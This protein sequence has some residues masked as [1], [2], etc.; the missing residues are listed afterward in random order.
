[1]STCPMNFLPTNICMV[2]ALVAL[3]VGLGSCREEEQGR[4][5]H[6]TQGV[7]EG[8]KDTPLSA[9]QERALELRGRKQ[10]F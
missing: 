3:A 2:A 9:E 1:M 5:L 6:Y 10:S 8:K 4:P 7:Y